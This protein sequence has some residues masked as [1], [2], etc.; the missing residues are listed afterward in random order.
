DLQRHTHTLFVGEPTGARIDGYGEDVFLTLP[1]SKL[2]VE[3]SAL[4]FPSADRRPWLAPHIAAELSSEDYRKNNDPAW[5]AILNYFPE[6]DLADK[7]MDVLAAGG[8]PLAVKEYRQYKA[9]PAHKYADYEREL[10]RVGYRLLGQ[11][12]FDQAI[13]IF[14]LNLQEHP[15]AATAF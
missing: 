7:M 11:K 8:F 6:K 4:Y 10:N 2:T 5:N 15:T 14:K 13:E 9:N 12:R 1:N 3:Y